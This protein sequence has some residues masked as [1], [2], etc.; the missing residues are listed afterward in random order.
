[1]RLATCNLKAP[2]S[3]LVDH[4]CIVVLLFLYCTDLS[5]IPL[6]C[7]STF[8]SPTNAYSLKGLRLSHR[9]MFYLTYCQGG[10]D[11]QGCRLLEH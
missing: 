2:S 5:C 9:Y 3:V 10:A 6:A 7:N 11:P 1:V 4:W 8:I